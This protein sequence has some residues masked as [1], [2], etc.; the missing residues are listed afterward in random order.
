MG[1]NLTEAFQ[2]TEEVLQ[3]QAANLSDE[4]R[5]RLE[6]L[7]NV[8]REIAFFLLGAWQARQ[9]AQ[10]QEDLTDHEVHTSP[11]RRVSD[12]IVEGVSACSPGRDDVV[13]TEER[14]G[15]MSQYGFTWVAD[16]VDRIQ[17][18]LAAGATDWGT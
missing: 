14:C 9:D 4:S 1:L 16:P 7:L 17:G 8:E 13:A 12:M 11:D 6:R 10:V 5:P 3:Q 18:F 15:P 2:R